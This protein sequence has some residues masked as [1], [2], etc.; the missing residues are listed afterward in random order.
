MMEAAPEF[1]SSAVIPQ[2]PGARLSSVF[3]LQPIYRLPSVGL[4]RLN[5]PVTS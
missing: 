1:S 5:L 2:I 3:G 4:N